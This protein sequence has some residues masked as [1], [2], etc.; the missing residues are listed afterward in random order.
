ML[1]QMMDTPLLISSLLE[2]G[3]RIG[4]TGKVQKVKLRE[5]FTGK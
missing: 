4:A 3:A 1:G 2:H 5:R